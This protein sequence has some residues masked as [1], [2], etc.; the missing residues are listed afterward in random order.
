[1]EGLRWCNIGRVSDKNQKHNT[2]T[3]RQLA[4]LRKVTEKFS[5]TEVEKLELVESAAN[6]YR[7]SMT[8]ILKMGY[9][10][11]I[12]VLGIWS[13]DRLTR[14]NLVDSLKYLL[15]L[16]DSSTY[17]YIHNFGFMD[18]DDDYDIGFLVHELAFAHK[19]RLRINSGGNDGQIEK[20]KQGKYPFGIPPFGYEKA[21][22]QTLYLTDLGKKGIPVIFNVYLQENGNIEETITKANKMLALENTENELTRTKVTTILTSHWTVGDFRLK[23]KL[24][25]QSDDIRSVSNEL[26]HSV[27][28]LWLKTHNSSSNLPVEIPEEGVQAFQRVGHEFFSTV[29]DV[30]S[31]FC[32]NCSCKAERTNASKVVRNNLLWVYNCNNCEFRDVLLTEEQINKLDSTVPIAC[33]YCYDVE[34][35]EIEKAAS[36]MLEY[37]YTCNRCKNKFAIDAHPNGYQRAFDHPEVAFRW[38]HGTSSFEQEHMSTDRRNNRIDDIFEW[39]KFDS[40]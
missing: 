40:E 2:S 26:F 39:V 4:V 29:F 21:D 22:D 23:G 12:D 33:P 15:D 34:D 35:F 27:Q 10:D 17:L 32:P 31:Q 16:H 14:A 8:N 9:D 37:I 36:C 25:T 38:G 5:G 11:K 18:W 20:L 1:M 7:E 19:W 24:I 13:V 3:K 6:M 30:L 28:K